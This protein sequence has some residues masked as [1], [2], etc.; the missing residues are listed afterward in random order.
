MRKYSLVICAVLLLLSGGCGKTASR[1]YHVGIDP[2][3]FPLNL[4]DQTVNVFAFSNELLREI[5]E[6]KGVELIRTNM[7]WDNLL[8]GLKLQKYEAIFS[9]VPPNLINLTKLSF[10]DPYLKTGP[11]LVVPFTNTEKTL[12]DLPGQ[13]VAID[14]SNAE[15]ELMSK[16]PDVQFDFYDRIPNV[17]EDVSLGKVHGALVP[18]IPAHA[19]V[20]NIYSKVLTIAT[21]PLTNEALRLITPK[22]SNPELIALFN[23]GLAKLRANGK[24][25][26]LVAK[27]FPLL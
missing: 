7:S 25:D 20:H 11:V 4:L 13:V 17:L 9:S 8:D 2:T 18:S 10:S 5:S 15:I 27:W 1:V 21:P 26:A 12:S 19:Y 24:Y 3:F 22:D 23:E 6:V 14:G 16:Y